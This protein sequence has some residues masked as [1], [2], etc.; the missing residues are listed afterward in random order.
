MI[1]KEDSISFGGDENAVISGNNH[2]ILWIQQK[3]NF[4]FNLF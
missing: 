3:K 2:R 1:T 4:F